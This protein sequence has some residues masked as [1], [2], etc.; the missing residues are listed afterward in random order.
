MPADSRASMSMPEMREEMG[1]REE[2]WSAAFVG[3]VVA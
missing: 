3:S 1:G 2:R